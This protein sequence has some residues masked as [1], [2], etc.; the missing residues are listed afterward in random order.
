MAQGEMDG[1]DF[2]AQMSDNGHAAADAASRIEQSVKD[3]IAWGVEPG[4]P[5]IREAIR[6]ARELRAEGLR[7]LAHHVVAKKKDVLGAADA[8]ADE[9]DAAI[10]VTLSKGCPADHVKIG[11]ARA[12][13]KDLRAE[14]G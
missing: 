14:E 1:D 7:R 8:A 5:D 6:L 13:V 10:K 2:K 9:I 11:K 3:A 12:I 4:L